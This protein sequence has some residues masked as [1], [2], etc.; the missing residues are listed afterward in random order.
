MNWVKGGISKQLAVE[1]GEWVKK[2]REGGKDRLDGVEAIRKVQDRVAALFL[3][4]HHEAEPPT[5]ASLVGPKRFHLCPYFFLFRF[6]FSL[7]RQRVKSKLH[8][9]ISWVSHIVSN[10]CPKDEEW[11]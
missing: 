8:S 7:K 5:T 10:H 11:A 6:L 4:S 9:E 1:L 3:T 2:F